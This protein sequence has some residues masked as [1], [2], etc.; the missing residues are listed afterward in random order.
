[1][2]GNMQKKYPGWF[3]S[4]MLLGIVILTSHTRVLAG[5]DNGIEKTNVAI[6]AGSTLVSNSSPLAVNA[7]TALTYTAELAENTSLRKIKNIIML[8]VF[9]ETPEYIP[10]DFT[11]SVSVRIKYGA[12]ASAVDSIDQLFEVTY[13]KADGAK[14]NAKRYFSFNNAPYVNITVLAITAPVVSGFD[15]RKALVLQNEMRTT[16]YYTLKAG[17]LPAT[18]TS[19]APAA[20]SDELSIT[21]SWPADA[22]NTHT[23]LEWTWLED[24]LA[25]AYQNGSTID[26]NLLFKNNSTRLDL[27]IGISAYKIPLLYGG[28]GKLYCRIR[29]VNINRTGNR[30]EGQWTTPQAQSFAGHNNALNWQATISF[31]E[32]GKRKAV[33][34]YYD[35]SLRSRQTVTKDNSTNTV[36]TSETFYDGQGRAAVQILPAPGISNVMGYTAGLNLFTGQK[37][38]DDPIRFFDMQPLATA[39]SFTPALRTDSG[40]V[41]ASKYYSAANPEISAGINAHIPDAEGYP[42]AVTRYTPDATGRVMAQSGAGAA[43]Q[44]GKGHETKYYY[45]T[46]AQEELDGLFGTEVGIYTHYFKNMAKDANGQMGISYIDMNGRTI[47]TALAGD[48]PTGMQ[49]LDLN[50]T[51]YPNQAGT[52]IT[53]NLLNKNTNVVKNNSVESVTSL[54]VPATT[55]YAFRYELTPQVLQLT[56][57]S[58]TAICYDCMY[59]LEFA[60]VDQ[61]GDGTPI[62]KKFNNIKLTPD[63][64]CSTPVASFKDEVTNAVS[65]IIQF[66][67]QLQPGSYTIRKTLTISEASVQTYKDL[68]LTKGLCKAEQ[69]L[70]DSVY[71]AL[72]T[73]ATCDDAPPASA[74]S[75]CLTSL[76]DSVTYR[77]AYLASLYNSSVPNPVPANIESEIR[78]GYKAAKQNCDRLCNTTSQVL[79][80]KR[81]MMLADMIPY[82]GQYARDTGTTAMYKKYNIF[83]TTTAGTQPF[84]KKP[85]NSIKGDDSYRTPN[86]VI[87]SE[88]MSRLSTLGAADFAG[89]F[90][91]SWAEQLLPYHPEYD[92]L[93]FAQD[94]LTAS[95]NWVTTFNNTTTFT[96][97]TTNGYIF[98]GAT[99]LN[100]PF[101]TTAASLK[102][103]MV[104]KVATNYRNGL[105][106]WQMAYGDVACKT[107][108]SPTQKN[109]C[110][111]SAAKYPPYNNLTATQKDQVWVTFRNLYAMVRDSQVNAYINARRPLADA[112]TLIDQG[113]L[114]QF[115]TGNQLAQQYGN[116]Q[117]AA[118]GENDWAWFPA[119]GSS[120][121]DITKV[122]DGATAAT[123]YNSRCSSYIT[124]WTQALLKCPAINNHASKTQIID[125]ITA[126]MVTVCQKGS[127][128]N[129][130]FGASNAAP[131]VGGTTASFEEVINSV[132]TQYGIAK[133]E[134]CNP[135]VIEFPK[136]YGKGPL[137]AKEM[138]TSLDTCHCGRFA[139]LKAEATAAGKD[140]AVLTSFN[141]YLLAAYGDTLSAGL[142]NGLTTGCAFVGTTACYDTVI[143]KTIP[144]GT[145]VPCECTLVSGTSYNCRTRICTTVNPYPLPGAQPMP[146]F[147]KC[148]FVASAKCFTCAQL[149]SLVTEF[150]SVL[151]SPY[152]TGPVFTG[153]DLDSNSIKY[154]ILFAKFVNYRTGMQYSWMEYAQAAT[155]ASCNLANYATNTGATQTVIC[156]DSKPLNDTTGLLITESPCKPVYNMAV[157]I[158]Q[159]LYQQRKEY[160]LDDF[161]AQYRAK[162][163]A[164]SS[165]EQF[166]VTYTSKEYHYTLYYYDMAGNLVKTVAPRGVRPDFS[167]AFISSVKTARANGT[168]LPR[169]HV[170][171]TNYRYNSLGQVLAVNSPDAKTARFWYDK[172]GRMVT[173]QNAQQAK[174]NKYT[175]TVYDALGRVTEAGQKPQTTA[176]TQTISQ[177]PVAFNSWINTSGGTREQIT[178][179][180]Y[181]TAYEAATLK[182]YM[183]QQNLSG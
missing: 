178:F 180:V 183:M 16:R 77:T 145:A 152:N 6:L 153:T 120:D 9:E 86:N 167:A 162:C 103:D 176:M 117:Q 90:A 121:P 23:Q 79:A 99:N 26:Y 55:N 43:L 41:G 155:K 40:F 81:T 174:D 37:G 29:A 123:T 91:Y 20:T 25:G 34:Q 63:D 54:L 101:Y 36:I 21:W 87:D 124:Q 48:A 168:A 66:T 75:A 93:V 8:S 85:K 110:Y 165:L 132:F 7:A 109:S 160:L 151:P 171:T 65:N 88:V 5:G 19:T 182:E 94:S 68:Y 173:G 158:A 135:F 47:A 163:L 13:T 44:M 70:I 139:K 4:A 138:V 170:L 51:R 119:A 32:E 116:Q 84:Y 104:T 17:V 89:Q 144:S 147:L 72:L 57:C 98:T 143:A 15:T 22:G 45:G 69:N 148:G 62:I 105:S 73:V 38:G 106:L 166:I 134:V 131:G 141:Q 118:A 11:A 27:P 58:N 146:E 31:A 2:T 52:S 129:N 59:N 108:V 169:S 181:D 142:Y 113:F 177:D 53:R 157:S 96:Q 97:A 14:Y 156:S 149:S 107:M 95:Y 140:P 133:T 112:Q 18:F 172:I 159:Q 164:A 49:A 82:S 61:S 64:S 33:I 154:N 83:S 28:T 78:A 102:T 111:T 161:E 175:Y 114:L 3:L 127:D 115:A 92:R 39:N 130:P 60:I 1:M 126:G 137:F 179:T 128:A 71:S 76:G 12:S 100:D 35:G 150:K 30:S 24:E 46:P 122:P 50:A 56:S 74:C 10:G 125:Q 67:Q 136:P 80:T 42:Y